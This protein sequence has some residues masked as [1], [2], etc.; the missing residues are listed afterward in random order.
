MLMI[1][2]GNGKCRSTDLIPRHKHHSAV[3]DRDEPEHLVPREDA[4]PG[5]YDGCLR[6]ERLDAVQLIGILE[7][8]LQLGQCE[9]IRLQDPL[10]FRTHPLN[11]IALVQLGRRQPMLDGKHIS[12]L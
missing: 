7:L 2:K 8:S 12:W 9:P 3:L 1:I 5:Y 6:C 11:S 4:R 10:Y